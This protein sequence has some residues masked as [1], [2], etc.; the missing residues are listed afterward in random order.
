MPNS[1]FLPESLALN[2]R[3]EI[4]TDSA[5]RTNIPG[6]YAAGDVTDSAYKQIII[7]MGSGATAALG[8]FD[9][10]MRAPLAEESAISEIKEGIVEEVSEE[11]AA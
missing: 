4:I 5:G 10:L 6:I 1:Q 7:A 8:S 3:G 9:Y 11:N 2:N